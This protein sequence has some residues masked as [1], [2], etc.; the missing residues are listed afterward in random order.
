MVSSRVVKEKSQKP[1]FIDL[2][3]GCGG[4]SLGMTDAGFC[5]LFAIE[6]A[7]EAFLTYKTNLLDHPDSCDFDWP[8]WLDKKN[9]GIEDFF[10]KHGHR[11]N[12]LKGKVSV[13]T[14]GPPCQGFSFAGRR[15]GKDPRN[16]LF[17]KYVQFVDAVKPQLLVLENVPGMRVAHGNSKP[18]VAGKKLKKPKSY[19]EKLLEELDKIGYVA[20]GR[21]LDASTFGVP[22]RRPRLV[23]VGLKRSAINRVAG[24]FDGIFDCIDLAGEDLVRA[25]NL[26][27]PVSSKDALSDL[28]IS[29]GPLV[30]C[31]DPASPKGFSMLRYSKPVS[32]YQKLMHRGTSRLEMDSM[33]LARHTA[34]VAERFALILDECRKG[35]NLSEADRERYGMLKHRTLPMSST[36]PAPT[37]TTLPDDVLHYSE[38][39]ILTVREYARIQSFP[40]W[41]QFKGKYT[42]GG[43]RRKKDCPRYTQIGN[44]VPPLLAE[45]VGNALMVIL[46]QI[47]VKPV[48]TAT[49]QSQGQSSREMFALTV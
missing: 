1:T 10:T 38:P 9:I 25:L 14:G 6:K 18:Q 7:A 2:F 19:Y 40:D 21:L 16:R 35:V 32:T 43:A 39:R 23:V 11:L 29:E 24:G 27:I 31:I 49:K 15:N 3:S 13:L 20:E 45:A 36:A 48:T 30:P 12:A 28:E 4:L 37:L 8:K 33:R 34:P 42:T 47:A 26:S 46:E 17:K 5:G 44:A 41:Y 22:Q